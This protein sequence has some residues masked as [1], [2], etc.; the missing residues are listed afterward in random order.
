MTTSRIQ[1]YNG[2]LV[3]HLGQRAIANLT[4]N[5]AARR[6]LDTAWNNDAVKWCLEKGQ[7]KFAMRSV[8]LDYSPSVEPGFPG[9]QYAFNLPDD[10]VRLAGV[11]QDESMK[12]PYLDYR[13][14]GGFLWGNLETMYVRYV[15]DDE[16]C[17]GDFSLWP[18]SFIEL[19]EI[20]LAAKVAKPLTQDDNLQDKLEA[21]RDRIVLKAALAR[22]AMEEP[23]KFPP[24]GSWVKSR[25][26]GQRYRRAGDR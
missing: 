14:E 18:Q 17:G 19:V 20:H 25:F 10:L 22:D 5:E 16:S 4:V 9:L 15:S 1:L 7:W 8:Q 11:F 6:Y 26:S 12:V 23:T 24:P 13:E 3:N 2:A 21:K